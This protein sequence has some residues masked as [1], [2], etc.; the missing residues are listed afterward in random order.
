MR[1]MM[2]PPGELLGVPAGV[3]D[4][5][6]N[7]APFRWVLVLL[8]IASAFLLARARYRA[9]MAVA[10]V[11]AALSVVFWVLLLGR[12]YGVLVDPGTT[13]RAAQ[14]AVTAES[15][16]N[17]EGFLVGEPPAPGFRRHIAPRF[18]RFA[19]EA[20]TWLPV[21][22]LP[23]TALGL[24]RIA[25]PDGAVAALLWLL[26]SSGDLDTLRGRG[27]VP[28]LWQHPGAA[29]GFTA[30]LWCLALAARWLTTVPRALSAAAVVC[31]V[32]VALPFEDLPLPAFQALAALTLDQALWLWLAAL[33]LRRGANGPAV[34]FIVSGAALVLASACGVRVD[35]WAAHALYRAG[36]ILASVEPL[37]A[38]SARIGRSIVAARPSLAAWTPA[39]LGGGL[40]LLATGPGATLAWWEPLRVDAI[41]RESV[42]PIPAGV[43]EPMEWIR[44]ETA[45]D[46]VFVASPEYAPAVAVLAGRRVLRAPTLLV[47]SDDER[48]RRVERAVLTGT[49]PPAPALLERYG[50]RYVLAAPG[51]FQDLGLAA[52]HELAQRPYLALRHVSRQGFRVYEI[53][54]VKAVE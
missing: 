28:A 20:P 25:G 21:L 24:Y 29:L 23:L 53:V 45:G 5:M 8:V 37:R 14:M 13:R 10:A 32:S 18:A 16:R 36:L 33:G 46:A 34:A 12:P 6:T 51:D 19:V 41:A 30:L 1:G 54:G 47:A 39:A 15:G 2:S 22:L 52:P 38:L 42:A 3:P 43:A 40:L 44:R 17:D 50:L 4:L 31:A 48:R 26:F 49:P 9:A 7:E 27:F 11:C 35:V